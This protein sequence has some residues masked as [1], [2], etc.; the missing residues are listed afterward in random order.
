MQ[1]NR[2][3]YFFIFSLF[4]VI[5]FG[6]VERPKASPYTIQTTYEKLKKEFPFIKPLKKEFPATIIA[7]ENV[8]YKTIDTLQLKADIYSPKNQNNNYP[9]IILI[10]GGGWISGSKENQKYMAQQLAKNGFVAMTINY[11]LADIAKYPAPIKDI[12][13]AINYLINNKKEYAINPKKIAILGASAGAQLATL[14][15]VKSKKIKAIIN[16]DGIVSFVHP[17]AE[18]GQYAAYWLGNWKEKNLSLWKE[19]SPLEYVNKHTPPTLFINSSQPRFHA[20]RDD[21]MKLLNHYNIYTEM[22]E[23]KDSPHSFWLLEPW[24][25]ETLDFTVKFLNKIFK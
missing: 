22:H 16:V 19:A 9:A 17:E 23:I 5:A 1:S 7:K 10:H 14:V 15:G 2:I 18:E 4:M 13:Q 20:G 12:D 24:F 8:I 21:M 11:R 3:Y 25:D 6:Q